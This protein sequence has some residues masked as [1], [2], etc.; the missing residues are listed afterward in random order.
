MYSIFSLYVLMKVV[1]VLYATLYYSCTYH[2]VTSSYLVKHYWLNF[3][4]NSPTS[5]QNKT[6][7]GLFAPQATPSRHALAVAWLPAAN[8]LFSLTANNGSNIVL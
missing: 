4:R 7:F 5:E 3:Y 8:N 6:F 1:Y 2:V